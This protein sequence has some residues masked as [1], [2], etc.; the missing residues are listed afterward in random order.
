MYNPFIISF[1]VYWL[2]LVSI[3]GFFFPGEL[4]AVLHGR[5]DNASTIGGDD[6]VN[7]GA[8]VSFC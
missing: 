1:N 8:I 4:L 6:V 2:V 3:P 5:E 7:G